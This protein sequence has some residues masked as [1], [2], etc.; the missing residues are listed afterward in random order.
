MEIIA[1]NYS[2]ITLPDVLGFLRGDKDLPPRAVVIT[3]DDGYTDN[4]EIAAPVLS[5]L[6]IPAVFYITVACVEKRCLPWPARLRYAFFTTKKCFWTSP[7]GTGLALTTRDERGRAFNTASDYCARLSGTPQECF[8]SAVEC[9]MDVDPA[10]VSKHMMMTWDQVRK[11]ASQGH[12]IGSHTMTHPN[13]AHISE[14]EMTAEL[15]DS[16]RKLDAEMGTPIVH[17]AY[18]EPA[19]R[20]NWCAQS[21]EISR[22]VGYETAVTIKGGPVRR[23]DDPLCLRRI[24]PGTNLDGFLWNLERTFLGRGQ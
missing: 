24:G 11:L 15:G 16:K 14:E 4:L 18:P 19:L 9:E 20:P 7:R 21:R 10:P 6:G 5:H 17:F 3:F 22:I 13:L 23:N 12:T 8:V 2:P 1:R